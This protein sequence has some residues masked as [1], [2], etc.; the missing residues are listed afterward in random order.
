MTTPLTMIN[1]ALEGKIDFLKKTNPW[2]KAEDDADDW[3][4]RPPDPEGTAR[5]LI[6]FVQARKGK[7][8]PRRKDDS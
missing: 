7:P 2:G 1:V 6:Q 4:S 3:Q 8:L 5:K